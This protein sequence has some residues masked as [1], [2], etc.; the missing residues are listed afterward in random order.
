MIRRKPIRIKPSA[1]APA[2]A[3]EL[4]GVGAHTHCAAAQ[5]LL[6]VTVGNNA[7]V[8]NPDAVEVINIVDDPREARITEIWN[9]AIEAAARAA[10]EV[11][12]NE[13]DQKSGGFFI[14]L[15]ANESATAIRKLKR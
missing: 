5:H 9:D 6:E 13:F 14:S 1:I 2:R 3:P 12:R 7:T 8:L 11:A 15:G 10:E 4:A